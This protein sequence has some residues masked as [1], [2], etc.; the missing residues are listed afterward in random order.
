MN[1][2]VVAPLGHVPGEHEAVIR[3]LKEGLNN[4]HLRKPGLSVQEMQEW[5]SK[6]PPELRRRITVHAPLT[7]AMQIGVGGMHLRES[8]RAGLTDGDLDSIID[9]AG[10]EGLRVT[11]S[12]HSVNAALSVPSQLHYVFL[13][14]AFDSKSKP[15]LKGSIASWN[16]PELR[17]CKIYALGGVTPDNVAQVASYG[18]DGIAV[19]GAVWHGSA[20]PLSNFKALQKA[21]QG[22]AQPS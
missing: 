12:V 3:M 15:G 5:V 19:L 16:L 20:D 6:I 14:Q 7:T 11:A 10:Q 9:R 17:P 18:V 21:C 8:D 1:L 13:S 2:T 4:Y 22:V